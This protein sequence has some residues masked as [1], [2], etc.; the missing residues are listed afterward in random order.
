[1]NRS[2]E[3]TRPRLRPGPDVGA[4]VMT[5]QKAGTQNVTFGKAGTNTCPSKTHTTAKITIAVS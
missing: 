4:D 3:D 2:D 5:A 1:M